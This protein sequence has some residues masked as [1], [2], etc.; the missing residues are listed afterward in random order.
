MKKIFILA[1]AM[2]MIAIP[3]L[4]Q[5]NY[6]AWQAYK[7]VTI[8]TTSSGAN[9][10]NPV[11]QYPVLV[12]LGTPDSDVFAAAKTDGADV[13]FSKVDGTHL[14]YQIDQWD[15]TGKTAAIWVLL[16][17]V[18]GNAATA[19]N[20]YFGNT[21]AADSSNG[22]AVFTAANGFAAVYHLDEDSG[23]TASGSAIYKDATGIQ[24]AGANNVTV[25]GN[26]GY[27]GRGTVF[28][29]TVNNTH[30]DYIDLG[31]WEP[32]DT[33]MTFSAWV[34]YTP[35]NIG[36]TWYVIVAKRDTWGTGT[37]RWEFYEN[38]SNAEVGGTGTSQLTQ[39]SGN[40]GDST[41]F[42]VYQEALQPG[43][44]TQVTWTTINGGL[45]GL[46]FNGV[47]S[48]TSTAV[49]F[50]WGTAATADLKI[51]QTDVSGEGFAGTIDEARFSSIIRSA[52]WI[53]LDYQTQKLGTTAITLGPAIPNAAVLANRTNLSHSN[54]FD[55]LQIGR[56]IMFRIPENA[57]HA[58]IS[59]I[60]LSGRTVTTI[61]AEKGVRELTWKG[62]LVAGSYIARLTFANSNNGERVIQETRIPYNP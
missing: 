4:A 60:A 47:P 32:S 15:G 29:D 58:T 52:D 3:V 13:R 54:V 14:P 50:N 46:Y 26:D 48:S 1:V 24:A 39:Y 43:V 44:W 56:S 36:G 51:G 61:N 27:I 16:D 12:R 25:A 49:T 2:A 59:L 11:M 41:Y 37:M 17:T 9:I 62:N 7:T 57:G 20:M 22:K 8:N 5:E 6:S 21:A 10:A 31:T 34:K 55:A 42:H 45:S 38:N 19:V 53:N 35:S 40:T 33:Q 28:G 30:T 18:K 23:S